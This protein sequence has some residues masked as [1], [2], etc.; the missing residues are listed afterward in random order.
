MVKV[1]DFKITIDDTVLLA[2]ITYARELSNQGRAEEEQVATDEDY[3]AWIITEASASYARDKAVADKAAA[4]SDA[5]AGDFTKFD[6]LRA[7]IVATAAAA[8]EGA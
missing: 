2:G 1:M 7:D 4:I 6:A 5:E 8:M 3:V